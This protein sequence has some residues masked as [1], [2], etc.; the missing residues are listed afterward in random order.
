MCANAANF[1]SPIARPGPFQGKVGTVFFF[2]LPYIEQNALYEQAKGSVTTMLPDGIAVFGHVVK[3]YLCPSDPSPS[4][5]THLGPAQDAADSWAVGNYVANYL[6]FGNPV[7]GST[8]GAASIPG[9]F[10]DGT[11]NTMLYAERYGSCGNSPPLGS[12]WADSKSQTPF[13]WR[14]QVCNPYAVGYKQCTLFQVNPRWDLDCDVF[15]A[16]SG[17]PGV[18]QVALGDGSVRTVSGSISAS[19][20]ANLCDPRDGMTLGNDW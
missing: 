10:T 9:T 8:E 15:R 6:V 7:T 11:S 12:L 13:I 16:Q 19:T 17:H 2:L 14:P 1:D 3:P 20:W 4:G 5:T 18:I